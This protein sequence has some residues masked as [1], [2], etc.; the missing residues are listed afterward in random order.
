MSIGGGVIHVIA[1]ILG[2]HNPQIRTYVNGAL[3]ALLQVHS[4]EAVWAAFGLRARERARRANA[5]PIS[6]AVTHFGRDVR[7]RLWLVRFNGR[8]SVFV[9]V[10]M[11]ACACV[12]AFVCVRACVRVCVCVSVC[13]SV[14]VCVCVC[15]HI[16]SYIQG[17]CIHIYTNINV[18][19]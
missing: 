7:S 3:Y 13:V 4:A 5:S 6:V 19:V 15:V 1:A 10:C 17:T 16:P 9:R 18:R 11:R 12:R 2:D 8:F 14:C